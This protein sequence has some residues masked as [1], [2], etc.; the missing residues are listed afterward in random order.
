[1]PFFSVI[2]PAYNRFDALQRAIASVHAQTYKDFELIIVDDGSDDDTPLL[3]S[4]SGN[5][6]KYI[7]Q[8]NCG[9]SSARNNGIS[10]SNAQYIAFL[11]SDDQWLPDKLQEQFIYIKENPGIEIH[12]TE[13][14][15]IRNGRRVNSMKKHVK[16]EGDIFIN[17]LDLC[18]ISPSSVVMNRVLFEKYGMFDVDLPVCEDYDLWLRITGYETVGLI[19]KNLIIKYGGHDSQLSKQYWGMDRFRIYAIIKLL[20]SERN[21]IKPEY[22]KMAAMT[23]IRKC[24][25]LLDGALKRD[26][27]EFAEKVR[28]VIVFLES[29]N[30]SSTN[31]SF[32]LEK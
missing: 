2:I 6:I 10:L 24:R 17:S 9:V 20:R 32:L 18:M 22:F 26:K 29:E 23:A 4:K 19:K 7:R 16:T 15:W 3:A 5:S 11:D 8:E 30:Y 21:K 12:Q 14:I 1:M 28:Q 25:I 31:L 27:I 13:E